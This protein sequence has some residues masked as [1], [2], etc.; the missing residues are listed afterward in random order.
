[1][2]EQESEKLWQIREVA[3]KNE[4]KF[5]RNKLNVLTQVRTT[6]GSNTGQRTVEIKEAIRESQTEYKSTMSHCF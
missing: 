6:I 3:R 5:H 1:M 4:A 2:I